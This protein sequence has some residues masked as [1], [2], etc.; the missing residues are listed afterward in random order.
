MI[1]AQWSIY[2]FKA[3]A[4]LQE[5]KFVQVRNSYRNRR[6]RRRVS[7]YTKT[8]EPISF[9]TFQ[10]YDKTLGYVTQKEPNMTRYDP[11]NAMSPSPWRNFAGKWD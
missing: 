4:K 2:T 8:A 6:V 10:T 7:T 3:Q 1:S 9:Q 5:L 11:L